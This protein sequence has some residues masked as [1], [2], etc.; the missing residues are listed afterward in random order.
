MI[1]DNY[2]IIKTT[3]TLKVVINESS[4]ALKFFLDVAGAA[5][6][7]I[8]AVYGSY[9]IFYKQTIEQKR[10]NHFINI[11]TK[12]LIPWLNKLEGDPIVIQDIVDS[13]LFEDLERHFPELIYQNKDLEQLGKSLD[14][15]VTAIREMLKKENQEVNLDDSINHAI[16]HRWDSP[17]TLEDRKL[18]YNWCGI[19]TGENDRLSLFK[20]NFEKLS[21]EGV[22]NAVRD[23]NKKYFEKREE[24]K[25]DIRHCCNLEYLPKECIFLKQ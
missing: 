9:C 1:M 2:T 15:E 21:H 3:D 24:L 8:I 14:R 11:K 18:S 5:L 17:I 19:A 6:G 13:G 16:I 12:V 7:A 4:I 20:S 23:I 22:F 25:R 10:T